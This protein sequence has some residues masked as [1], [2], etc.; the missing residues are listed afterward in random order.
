MMLLVLENSS[1]LPQEVL[2][3][4]VWALAS[5]ALHCVSS[6]LCTYPSSVVDWSLL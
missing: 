4:A 1:G 3:Q 5:A 6:L 2:L